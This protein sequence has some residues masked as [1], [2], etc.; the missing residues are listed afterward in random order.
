[1]STTQHVWALI[2]A[3]GDGTRLRA[4]T[5]KPCGTAVPKQ[6]CSL[7]GGRSLLE[8][9]IARAARVVVPERICTIV[10]QQH[11]QWWSEC[12]ELAR[13][14]S[15]NLIVQP[16]NRGTGIGVLY[17]VLHILARD[18]HAQI[19]ILPS[20]HFVRDESVLR[21]ALVTVLDRVEEGRHRPVLLGM[22][23]D[24]VDT[25]L[26]YVLPGGPDPMGGQT[27][28]EFIEKPTPEVAARLIE[29]GGL[30]NTFIIAAHASTISELFLPRFSSLVMEMKVILSHAFDVGLPA[31][32]WPALVA[33]YARLPDLDFSRDILAD[34]AASLCVWRVPPCGWSDLGTPRRV[35]ETLQRLR[36]QRRHDAPAHWEPTNYLNLARQHEELERL[37]KLHAPYA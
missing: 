24:Q 8:E 28:A 30:W 14:P 12:R 31:G 4:L 18:P 20:D 6:F 2:L 10:A 9:A 27:V 3:G 32:G 35:G 11:H 21:D 5:T 29:Q 16:R 25:D 1:M 19:L 26:G 22:E 37:G 17:G 13:L 15:E 7:D 33:L 34:K 23:P 36:I